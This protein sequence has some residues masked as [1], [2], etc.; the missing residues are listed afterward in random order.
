MT[1]QPSLSSRPSRAS[2]SCA[3]LSRYSLL[4]ILPLASPA[5]ASSCDQLARLTLPHTT[6]ITA[7]SI[8]TGTFTPD[9]GKPIL[10]LPAFCRVAASIHPVPD[11]DIRVEMWLPQ[12]GNQSAWNGRMEAT[13][14]GGFAGHIEYNSMA[15]G[16][17]LGYAVVNT[18]MGMATP[19]GKDAAAFID[20]PERWTDWGSRA[21]HEMTLFAKQLVKAYYATGPKKSYFVGCST[22]GEQALM[23]AQRFPDDYDGIVGGAPAHNRTG[24]HTSVL[25]NFAAIQKTP[26]SYLPPEK[27]SLL[28]AAV[29][30]SCDVLDGVKDGLIAD[31]SRCTFD[32]ASLQCKAGDTAACLTAPQVA[33]VKSIYAGPVNPRTHQQIYPG[34]PL[35]S[36]PGWAGLGPAPVAGA[37]VPYAPIFQW[38]FGPNWD[39]R[40]FDY[41]HDV[42]T[43]N[44]RLAATLNATDPNL[45]TFRQ[46]G[47]KLLLYHGWSDWLVAPQ[48]TIDYYNAVQARAAGSQSA[49]DKNSI[50][51]TVKLFMI[52]GMAHCGGGQSP[53]NFD[54]LG[55][56]VKWVESGA[57][58]EKL[59]AIKP[60]S[61]SAPG[62][63]PQK[64]LLCPYPQVAQFQGSGDSNDVSTYTC[65]KPSPPISH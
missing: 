34:I 37:K 29:V 58:P 22:G 7:Q 4:V 8:T 55:A 50:D 57:A 52:P 45:D 9:G 18:D 47:H 59:I 16:V 21:T 19:P 23:E 39:W 12:L 6:V 60:P 35:G 63:A 46:R 30:R 61:E 31:P 53:G 13:G 2:L 28:S 27:I 33:T 24:V 26:V 3:S 38:V 14:N 49:A 11:S 5:F 56:M 54:P 44:Q 62:T 20:R 1:N 65:K 40:T 43:L 41:D 17:R 15:A 64:H 48:E 25:W 51:N 36:E 42:D 10:D 32:P